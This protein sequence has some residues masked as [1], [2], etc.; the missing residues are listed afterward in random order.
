MTASLQ[1]DHSSPAIIL[2]EK[3]K[4]LLADVKRSVSLPVVLEIVMFALVTFKPFNSHSYVRVV[5]V[6]CAI[7]VLA[8][9]YIV[10]KL[11]TVNIVSPAK[12]TTGKDN[13]PKK[14]QM[15]RQANYYAPNV[16]AN[17]V[18]VVGYTA[19]NQVFTN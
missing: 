18:L 16:S 13:L 3:M 10:T 1:S 6:L 7:S 14:T 8:L 17:N 11:P 5:E 12:F 4:P 9:Q 15:R 19:C 2:H